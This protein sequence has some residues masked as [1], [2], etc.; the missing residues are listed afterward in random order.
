MPT[1][2]ERELLALAAKQKQQNE[3]GL[4][5]QSAPE[6]PPLEPGTLL[7]VTALG[8]LQA[9]RDIRARDQALAQALADPIGVML[10]STRVIDT[11]LVG[12]Q[13]REVPFEMSVAQAD[14]EAPSQDG[15]SAATL[16]SLFM[17]REA[18]AQADLLGLAHIEDWA[19]PEVDDM[20][21]EFDSEFD[22]G[23][24]TPNEAVRFRVGRDTPPRMPFD[25]GRP[26][27]NADGRIVSQRGEDGRFHPVNEALNTG[28]RPMSR[29]EART[30]PVSPV[31]TYPTSAPSPTANRAQPPPAPPEDRSHY[32]TAADLI[33]GDDFLPDD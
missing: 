23:T 19:G 25:H 10:P 5:Q 18:Q 2:L 30:A 17:N 33:A 1:D 21:I 12:V 26:P 29:E 32:P 9:A 14:L 6:L 11:A 4:P 16:A 31:R 8:E 13:V 28:I 3:A 27:I 24:T 7:S 20:P 15:I 22:V